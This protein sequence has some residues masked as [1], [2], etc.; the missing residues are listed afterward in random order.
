MKAHFLSNTEFTNFQIDYSAKKNQTV[1]KSLEK[2]EML[3]S[4]IQREL[5]NFQLAKETLIFSQRI[6]EIQPEKSSIPDIVKEECCAFLQVNAPFWNIQVLKS[7]SDNNFPALFNTIRRSKLINCAI[8]AGL[9]TIPKLSQIMLSIVIFTLITLVIPF[10]MIKNGM[11]TGPLVLPVIISIVAAAVCAITVYF[12]S[13]MTILNG[14]KAFKQLENILSVN[15]GN[16]PEQYQKFID[17][18]STYFIEKMPSAIL[19]DEPSSL[20]SLTKDVLS[21]TIASDNT[22]TIGAVLWIVFGASLYSALSLKEGYGGIPI[23][24][25]SYN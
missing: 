24:T 5:T 6:I 20:D 14:C 16:N 9:I 21:R 3:S 15:A 19:I 25:Y 22:R 4:V 12:I 1:L 10:V 23:N 17:M 8:N 11:T 2:T 18:L 13:R 7:T